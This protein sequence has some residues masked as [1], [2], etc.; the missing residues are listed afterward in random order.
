VFLKDRG[1]SNRPF[2]Q[3]HASLLK[4]PLC[5]SRPGYQTK[6][7]QHHQMEERHSLA[8]FGQDYEVGHNGE[9]AF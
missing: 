9:C 1:N 8:V 2:E 6:L 7:L 5:R 3:C 4:L